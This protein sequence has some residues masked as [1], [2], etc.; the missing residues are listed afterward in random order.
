MMNSLTPMKWA[1]LWFARRNL[2]SID[3]AISLR[4]SAMLC[5]AFWLLASPAQSHAEISAAQSAAS[6]QS[7]YA[8]SYTATLGSTPAEGNLLL[9][10]FTVKQSSPSI[11]L[12]SGFTVL[13]ED[14]PSNAYLLVAAK[15]AGSSE[16]SSITATT[17][18]NSGGSLIVC[19]YESDFGFDLGDMVVG[20]AFNS[21][22]STTTTQEAGPLAVDFV[23]LLLA[24]T[25]CNNDVSSWSG[26][27][28]NSFSQIAA[29][30]GSN[31]ALAVSQRFD[32]ESGSYSTTTTVSASRKVNGVIIGI[33][34]EEDPTVSVTG[35]VVAPSSLD[36]NMGDMS[37]VTATIAP[38]NAT[39]QGVSWSSSNGSVVSVSS[40]GIVTAV[41][42][43][44]ATIT[45]TTVDGSFTDDC[46]VT[47]SEF[48]VPVIDED[49]SAGASNFTVVDGGD[50]GVSGGRYVLSNPQ[51]F[52]TSGL[53]GQIS[54]HDT[55]LAGDFSA[56]AVL[57]ITG[58]TGD[59]DDLA[60][61]FNYQDAGN[62]YYVSLNENA[63][64]NAYTQ[65]VFK[66]VNDTP[67]ELADITASISTDTDYLVEVVRSGSSIVAYI[68]STQVASVS[69]STFSG[70]KVGLG[71]K[72]NGGEFDDLMA[73]GS[74]LGAQAAGSGEG[75]YNNA[76][77]TQS[78]TF[79]A[80]FSV[81]PSASPTN[82][83]VALA[84]GD[85]S[86]YN[87]LAAIVRFNNSGNIDARNGSVYQAANTISYS[88]STAY[89]FRLEVDVSNH[90]YS[91]YVTPN[92]GS[93]QTIG[94]DFDFRTQQSSVTSLDTWVTHVD[95]NAPGTSIAVTEFAIGAGGVG[96]VATPSFSPTG[97]TFSSAQ[98]V[99]VST[100]T[101]GAAIRYTTD[102]STP[103]STSGIV[104]S[105]AINI[106]STTT[107]KAIAYKSGM[108]DSA[109]QT[110]TYTI[111]SQVEAPVFSP[112]GGFYTSTQNVTITS[113]TSGATIRFTTDGGTP[114]STTGTVYSGAVAIS[115]TT[116]LKAV[117]YKGG[118]TDSE[119]TTEGYTIGSAG[120]DF[121]THP[122]QVGLKGVGINRS[123]LPVLS[124][125]TFKSEN[126]GST[127]SNV[128]FTGQVTLNDGAD[129]ITFR[130]CWFSGGTYWSVKGASFS[131]PP[132]NTTFEDCDFGSHGSGSW[133]SASHLAA[134][135]GTNYIR[136]CVFYNS[137]DGIKWN[138]GSI[139]YIEDSW[140][141]PVY[142]SPKHTDCMQLDQ[143]VRA[144]VYAT[145]CT[146]ENRT[147]KFGG[148][149]AHS[150]EEL[151]ESTITTSNVAHWGNSI[152][153]TKP[154]GTT[155]GCS[156]PLSDCY[157]SWVDCI[158]TGGNYIVTAEGQNGDFIDNTVVRGS[159]NASTDL[160]LRDAGNFTVSGNVFH[161]DNAAYSGGA[162]GGGSNPTP[163]SRLGL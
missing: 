47:V 86:E 162:M 91:A 131:S 55:V 121:P 135:G 65:G 48:I 147:W 118:M 103:S 115:S 70:G 10:I 163:I 98:N 78:G 104:Y 144:K 123:E 36:M 37:E 108:T 29:V 21:T 35:V 11:T 156:G 45:A 145:R 154:C 15:L 136:R 111:S 12:P 77:A 9:L 161:D 83:Q 71:S 153:Q 4:L 60:L 141:Q 7:S 85:A 16:S 74:A 25:A 116:T 94:E 139:N 1:G 125:H 140:V 59:W 120:A 57:N 146:F 149:M 119:V 69:D 110:D 81:T 113:G 58:T 128:R 88:G 17:T 137:G 101:G 42:A 68:D 127:I 75:F 8:S 41:A 34:E 38:V 64:S 20:H 157:F 130:R 96:A 23:G 40:D 6:Y 14:Y 105:G 93:E 27:W 92:G 22:S 53:L 155:G 44:S 152:L 99:T 89:H 80:T 126:A 142:V 150:Q 129:N 73:F 62:F 102:G 67:T 26:S 50:W 97:G 5:G 63:T 151:T 106:S 32:V 51:T 52:T 112:S 28:T 49:F 39:E 61:I 124:N 122:D 2:T 46:S 100:A 148:V 138:S 117:A 114:T 90:T 66:V 109:I 31:S 159:A 18:A 160:G 19:E 87:D 24:A 107:L 72:N 134:L 43:G 30:N 33:V 82:A 13:A 143:N 132:L 84:D 56:G 54:V 76:F 79:S 3:L 95:A 158:V 133:V